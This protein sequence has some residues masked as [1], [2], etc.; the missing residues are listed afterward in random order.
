VLWGERGGNK[1]KTSIPWL[2]DTIWYDGPLVN[3][4]GSVDLVDEGPGGEEAD[5]AC[6]G[7]LVKDS[8]GEEGKG[9]KMG[10][11]MEIAGY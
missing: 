10:G 5:C 2:N 7:V 11:G 8:R 6:V 3:F 4:N 9:D 1:R